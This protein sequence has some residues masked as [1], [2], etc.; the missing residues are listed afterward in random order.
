[1]ESLLVEGEA[2][3]RQTRI[4][5]ENGHNFWSYR[6]IALKVLQLFPEGVFLLV[7]FESLLVEAEVFSRQTGITAENGHNF[8]SYRWIALKF[9][10]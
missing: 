5:A 2:L 4:T 1:M 8:W 7:A 6:W 10:Q 3:S 9:L